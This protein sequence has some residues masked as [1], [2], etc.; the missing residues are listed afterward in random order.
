MVN[1]SNRVDP[2]EPFGNLLAIAADSS[3]ELREL[4]Q[5]CGHSMGEQ[6]GGLSGCCTAASCRTTARYRLAV[7]VDSIERCQQQLRDFATQGEAQG[8]L[9]GEVVTEKPK[10]A[11][12]FTGQGSQYLDMG[13]SL[14]EINPVFRAAVDRCAAILADELDYPLLSVMFAAPSLSGEAIAQLLNQTQYTQPALFTI[15]YALGELWQA[16]GIKPQVVMGHSI[17]EYVAACIAGVFSLKDALKLVAAR[18]RLMQALPQTGAMMAVMSAVEKLE[19]LIAPYGRD[20]AIAAINNPQNVVLSGT[21]EALQQIAQILTEQGIKQTTLAVSH[22][23]HS[24]AMEPMIEAFHQIAAQVTYHPPQIDLISNVTGKLATHDITTPDYW[25]Q[26]ILQTVRFKDSVDTLHQEGYNTFLEI[27]PR[28]ILS[29]MGQTCRP[30]NPGLWLPSLQPGQDDWQQLLTSLGELYV[31]GYTIH[32]QNFD[33][34]LNQPRQA[35]PDFSNHQQRL[36]ELLIAKQPQKASVTESQTPFRE[37]LATL[38]K[39]QQLTFLRQT[40]RHVVGQVLAGI[41]PTGSGTDL[42]QHIP[43]DM[44]NRQFNLVDEWY[45]YF[46]VKLKDKIAQLDPG[47][48]V[49]DLCCGYGVAATT[50]ADEFPSLNVIGVDLNPDAEQVKKYITETQ[51]QTMRATLIAHDAC[52]MNSLGNTSIDFCY[53]MA[54][55]AYV[56]DGLQML[57][58]IYRVLKPGGRAFLYMMRRDD[59]IAHDFSLDELIQSAVGGRFVVHPFSKETIADWESGKIPQPYYLDGVILEMIK[60]SDD[61]SFPFEFEGSSPSMKTTRPRSMETYY[62]AGHY[63][64]ILQSVP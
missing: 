6:A 61:L 30:D 44:L 46:G 33:Q 38:P 56:P 54:G 39:E 2:F 8:C 63:Q 52:D 62:V 21:K 51:R 23:F 10:I 41:H 32:W 31:R 27:G 59:D 55:I 36:A 7:V 29:K 20:V 48:T 49:L 13:R 15:E 57:R 17:G 4:A 42:Q 14:Y 43:E 25:C 26:H 3:Q 58:E 35:V 12:V 22:A 40:L 50:L 18:G 16:W 1:L 24:P 9:V 11:F 45:R 47:Q 53:C 64:K 28:P 37:Q 60:T 5:R 19:P 34:H